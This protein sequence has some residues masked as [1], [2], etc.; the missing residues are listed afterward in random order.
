MN[1]HEISLKTRSRWV[2]GPAISN[3][4]MSGCRR[5]LESTILAKPAS[6]CRRRKLPPRRGGA[7]RTEGR[8]GSSPQRGGASSAREMAKPIVDPE[9][10]PPT[11]RLA[12]CGNLRVG[13]RP[14]T[15]A[16]KCPAHRAMSRVH[17]NGYR[18]GIQ[19]GSRS[20][21]RP[22]GYTRPNRTGHWI[23]ALYYI[24]KPGRLALTV[25]PSQPTAHSSH[26]YAE[27]DA[28]SV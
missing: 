16:T 14:L 26:V 13:Q 3:V 22:G 18:C 1:Q 7:S 25:S 27:L 4:N 11:Y 24:G 17:V 6:F 5:Y 8:G 23:V 20:G 28:C 9:Q 2:T 10:C 12:S 19:R 21:G 15:C